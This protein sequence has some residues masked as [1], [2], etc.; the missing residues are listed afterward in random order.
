MSE[1]KLN[2]HVYV[3]PV[4]NLRCIHCYYDAKSIKHYPN[5]FLTIQEIQQVICILSENF[6]VSFDV[7]GGEFF[8]RDNIC[9]LLELLPTKYLKNITITTNGTVE[10]VCNPRPLL[11]LDEFRVSVE[12]HTDELQQAIRGISLEPV[13][14]TCSDLM[15]KGIPIVLRI[16][17]H[18]QNYLLFSEMLK[19]FCNLGFTKFSFYEFQNSGRGRWSASE[20]E[21]SEHE[22]AIFIERLNLH[23]IPNEISLLKLSFSER[24]IPVIASYKTLL[25][26]KGYDIVDL[27]DIPSLT[28][29]YNGNLGT[30][31]WKIYSDPIGKYHKDSFLS[32]VETLI[33][34]GTL[35]HKCDH[36]SAIRILFKKLSYV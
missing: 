16:T 5:S 30:C 22:F 17:I 31:P 33:K 9:N 12:G 13:L 27:S 14:N 10:V 25:T 23:P 11:R 1:N 21:L 28:V 4:C 7:E 29:D 2:A 35:T 26:S 18:K 15:I 3:T 8:L 24:R 19:D 20:F 6:N 32:D 36:C 34:N